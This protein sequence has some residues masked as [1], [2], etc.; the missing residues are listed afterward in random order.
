MIMGRSNEEIIEHRNEAIGFF[1]E[2]FGLDPEDPVNQG[3]LSL[4]AVYQNPG[5]Q[6]R[7]YTIS[8]EAIPS[9]GWRVHDGG[10][11]LVVEDPAGITLA[12]NGTER[13]SR[14]ALSFPTATT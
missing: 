1:I 6:Y 13:T 7:A 9:S 11:I 12:A 3:R 8:G 2:R 10:W 14:K 5:I 4:T